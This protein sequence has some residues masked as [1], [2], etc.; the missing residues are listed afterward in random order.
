MIILLA[1]FAT[2]YLD[3]LK[4]AT[5]ELVRL[6][7]IFLMEGINYI[8]KRVLVIKME[9]IRQL[10]KNEDFKGL[11]FVNLV[12]FDSEYGHRKGL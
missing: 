1:P 3:N 8:S 7:E 6:K 4:E 9:W 11:C 2:T 5:L 10:L 12:E